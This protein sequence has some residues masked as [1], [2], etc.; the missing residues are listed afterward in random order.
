M[1]RTMMLMLV[2]RLMLR[3]KVGMRPEFVDLR[4]TL[5]EG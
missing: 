5:W 3:L 2:L 1:Q 4:Q